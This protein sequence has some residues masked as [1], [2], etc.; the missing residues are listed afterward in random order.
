MRISI[1]AAMVLMAIAAPAAMAAVDLAA[2]KTSA[3][4]AVSAA[5]ASPGDYAANWKASKA[6]RDY[7]DRM[8]KD[9]VQGW[10]D[11]LKVQAKQ[12]MKFAEIAQKINP[13]GIEGW[14]YYGLCVGDYSDS[15]SIVTALFEGLKDKTQLGFENAYKFDKSYDDY[16]PVL[17]L[18]RFWQV[19]PSV[20][21]RDLKKAETLFAEYLAAMGSK[22]GVDSDI[23]RFRGE[24]YRDTGRKDEARADFQKAAA[25]GNK[26]AAKD[27]AD[28]K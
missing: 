7:C 13:S 24:L 25:M 18:G 15:V 16:G 5:L 12:G 21:G 3:D 2:L 14:Y 22:P 19:L 1:I 17:A 9:N 23:W 11:V 28:L 27:L 26:D 6:L 8:E 20:A 4:T 10:K